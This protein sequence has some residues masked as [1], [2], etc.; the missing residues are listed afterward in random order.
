MKIVTYLINHKFGK[1]LFG[2]VMNYGIKL[3]LTALLTEML[4]LW[5][6]WSYVTSIMIAIII[7]FFY[8]MYITFKVKGRKSKRF[9]MYVLFILFTMVIDASLVKVF[10]EFLNIYYIMSIFIVT[11]ILVLFKFYVFNNAIFKK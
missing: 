1:Y 11:S 6:F 9:A 3:G 10:T 8:N 2:G 4:G 7:N 5:Y